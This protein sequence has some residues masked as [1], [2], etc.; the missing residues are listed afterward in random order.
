[1]IKS[2]VDADVQ[3][4][5]NFQR[6]R[7]PALKTVRSSITK[8]PKKVIFRYS[9]G[10]KNYASH[11]IDLLINWFGEINT[12]QAFGIYDDGND[13][14]Y[15]FVCHMNTGFEAIFLGMDG[16][17]YDQFEFDLFFDDK[18]I[19]LHNSCIEKP[20]IYPSRGDMRTATHN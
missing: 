4:V 18:L 20:V 17:I 9:N 6:R 10:M 12:V 5:V 13:P 16:L 8:N 3:I 1:M 19:S 15:S 7:D 11:A 2:A 14:N